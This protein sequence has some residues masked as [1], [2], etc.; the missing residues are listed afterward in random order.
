M[1]DRI[2]LTVTEAK[3]PQEVGSKG[4]KK[5]SFKG[6]STDGKELWYFSFKTSLFDSIK[7]DAELDAEVETKSREVDGN[8]YVD[9]QVQQLFVD[10]QPVGSTPQSRAQGG[11][12]RQS[13]PEERASIESQVAA[14]IVCELLVEKII[15]VTD[16]L[17]KALIS[18]CSVR[19]TS[20]NAPEAPKTGVNGTKPAPSTDRA[21][22][23]PKAEASGSGE[24]P[25]GDKPPKAT[26][27]PASIKTIMQL[28][29]A[30]FQDF[31][32]QPKGILAEMGVNSQ[33][34]LIETPEECYRKIAAV[35]KG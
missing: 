18:W 22:T 33:A 27:D 35:R 13:N 3:E 15:N 29:S 26:R 11:Y 23:E 1:S 5:L 7:K 8:T 9:R 14:K 24:K 19:L 6:K 20:G 16:T 12:S 4:A 31:Q 2:K 10:G 32:L 34:E 21:G 25:K 28:M 30:C 17:G